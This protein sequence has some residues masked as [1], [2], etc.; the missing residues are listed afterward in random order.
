[1]TAEMLISTRELHARTA[2]G[3]RVRLLWC[4]EDDR[5]FVAVNDHNTGD[6]FSVEVPPGE[7][8]LAVFDHPYAYAA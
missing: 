6:A 5:T 1:M 7:R 4:Q 3:I 2:A 8:A